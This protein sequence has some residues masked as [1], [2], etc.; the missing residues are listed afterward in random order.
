MTFPKLG[1][2]ERFFL[3]ETF[4]KV[5]VEILELQQASA[6]LHQALQAILQCDSSVI[7]ARVFAQQE[8]CLVL[9]LQHL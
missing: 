4:Q 6:S 8:L 2:G 3:T 1:K 7:N 9:V 5:S